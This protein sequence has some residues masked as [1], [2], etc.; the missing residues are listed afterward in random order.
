M[1]GGDKD[2]DNRAEQSEEDIKKLKVV[3]EATDHQY[4][5][6]QLSQNCQR[7]YGNSMEEQ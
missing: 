2:E 7:Y 6:Q 5:C 1:P 3:A 4:D